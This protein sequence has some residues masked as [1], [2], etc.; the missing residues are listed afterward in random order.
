MHKKTT[1]PTNKSTCQGRQAVGFVSPCC[2]PCDLAGYNA[3]RTNS[4][5]VVV[6][7][8]C[9]TLCSQTATTCIFLCINNVLKE[10]IA[11]SLLATKVSNVDKNAPWA[12]TSWLRVVSPFSPICPA[13]FRPYSDPPC[14]RRV[15]RT[16]MLVP[17]FGSSV[18][19][20][21]KLYLYFLFSNLE[22]IN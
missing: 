3:S 13:S 18:T 2:F 9:R 20:T 22:K 8:Q 4:V 21:G 10:Q 15:F 14:S 1:S 19:R 6:I 12:L 11:S 17:G 7:L 16:G 5:I